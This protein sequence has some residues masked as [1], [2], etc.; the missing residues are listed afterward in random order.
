MRIK[1]VF[2]YSTAFSAFVLLTLVRGMLFSDLLPHSIA[3]RI[4]LIIAAWWIAL[5]P[6]L[7]LMRWDKTKFFELGFTASNLFTQIALGVFA[8]IVL[9]VLMAG[10]SYALGIPVRGSL[11]LSRFL[12]E[13]LLNLV[14]VGLVEETVFRGYIYK[15]LF[16]YSNKRL[17]TVIVSSVLFGLFHFVNMPY[18]GVIITLIQVGTTTVIGLVFCL[19]R[20]IKKTFNMI[21]L[22]VLHSVYNEALVFFTAL[23]HWL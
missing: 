7:L 14:T 11:S 1:R 6:V 18:Q 3:P 10:V 8:G 16:D 23:F 17:F 15:K 5:V 13:S 22:I 2:Y 4:A 19:L 21:S 20:V 9:S 12:S